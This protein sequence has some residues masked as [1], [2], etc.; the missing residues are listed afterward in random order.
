M[1]IGR[2][3]REEV[4]GCLDVEDP[5]SADTVLQTQ[6]LVSD[7]VVDELWYLP[8]EPCVLQRS[9]LPDLPGLLLNVE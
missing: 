4:V 1:I 3:G 9:E 8:S 2:Q 6:L 5:S 7:V